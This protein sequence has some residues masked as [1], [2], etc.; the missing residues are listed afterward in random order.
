M[1]ISSYV[2]YLLSGI[3]ALTSILPF[4]YIWHIVSSVF[5]NDGKEYILSYAYMAVLFAFISILVYIAGILYSNMAAF[6]TASNSALFSAILL[7]WY[8]WKLA[9]VSIAPAVLGFTIMIITTI[10]RIKGKINELRVPMICYTVAVNS[11]FLF[12][13]ATGTGIARSG[14]SEEFLKNFMLAV[15]FAPLISVN[16]TQTMKL[17]ANHKNAESKSKSKSVIGSLTCALHN[18]TLMFPVWL[19]YS[20]IMYLFLLFGT[21]YNIQNQSAVF[22][23]S[24][25]FVCAFLILFSSSASIMNDCKAQLNGAII[26]TSIIT[27]SLILIDWRMALSALWVLPVSFAGLRLSVKVV[28]SELWRRLLIVSAYIVLRLGIV[29]TVLT[30]AFLYSHA[31]LNANTFI[32]FLLTVSRLYEPL[33]VSLQIFDNEKRP[34]HTA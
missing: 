26:S 12:L 7:F 4:W 21:G 1:K 30:G 11:A 20:F 10:E 8:D 24:T 28:R 16:F 23:L 19:M 13:I 22:Y 14:V 27:L 31:A 32:F 29:S 3:C 18:L 5:F 25:G 15:I 34:G 9:L 2:S 17:R 33:E 6:R